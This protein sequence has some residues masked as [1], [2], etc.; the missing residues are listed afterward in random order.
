M[1][2]TPYSLFSIHQQVVIF[3]CILDYVTS[4]FKTFQSTSH[5]IQRKAKVLTMTYKVPQT[6][7][8]SLQLLWLHLLP[9][10]LVL[11]HRPLQCSL[12]TAS[13]R[14]LRVLH[15]PSPRYLYSL[16]LYLFQISFQMILIRTGFP[17]HPYKIAAQPYSL[18]SIASV[19][20]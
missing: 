18:F 20:I 5:F 16:L 2:L 4:P 11:P 9:P 19:T 1:P 6:Q 15:L 17:N 14:H 8:S 10:S 3:K 7:S 13:T 12:N